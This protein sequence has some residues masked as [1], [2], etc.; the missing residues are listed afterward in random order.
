MANTTISEI[1]KL[2][3]AFVNWYKDDGEYDNFL[4]SEAMKAVNKNKT[5]NHGK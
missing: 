4:R 1:E 3:D 5:F 2:Y